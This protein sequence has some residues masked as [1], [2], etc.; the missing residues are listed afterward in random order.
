MP[1]MVFSGMAYCSSPR[2]TISARLIDTVN[3][4]RI[5][6][7]APLPCADSILI[8]PPSCLTSSC[9]TSMPSPR[10]EICVIFSAVEKPG[11]RMNCRIS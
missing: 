1:S 10:P 4:R 7:R 8:E 5:R 6:K 9:T 3:G 2:C 11:R